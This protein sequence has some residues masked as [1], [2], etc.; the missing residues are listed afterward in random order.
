MKDTKVTAKL[1]NKKINLKR[2]GW[3]KKKTNRQIIENKVQHKKADPAAHVTP[4]RLL[5]LLQTW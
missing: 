2:H 4:V 3:K 5:M 1:I